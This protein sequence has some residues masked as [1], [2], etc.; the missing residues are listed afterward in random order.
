MVFPVEEV[1]NYKGVTLSQIF[2]K[3]AT[4]VEDVLN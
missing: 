4:L 3:F 1:L 2:T